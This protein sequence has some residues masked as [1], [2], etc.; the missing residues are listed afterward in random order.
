MKHFENNKVE[1]IT[2]FLEEVALMQEKM[3][4]NDENHDAVLMMT[5]H[6][7]KGLEFN[8]VILAGLEDGLMPSSRALYEDNKLEEERRLFYV[9]ITRAQERLLMYYSRY[10][11]SYGQ[12][13]DQIPSRFLDEIPKRLLHWDDA[14]YWNTSQMRTFFADWLGIKKPT[15]SVMTFGT[16]R[17]FKPA[18]KKSIRTSTKTRTPLA[19]TS[20]S[21]K[22]K[23]PWK[24][25]QPVRH[26]KF[27]LGIVQKCEE[28]SNGKFFVTIKFKFDVKKID[29]QFLQRV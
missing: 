8:M 1:T 4:K 23:H 6:A 28:R 21:T 19:A 7:A 27:G 11:Y 3:S 29:A 10:R 5:L 20:S 15:A 14:S 26:S 13:A 24:K 18:I 12:M 22:T 25:N 16:A 2:Q 17:T 9:G